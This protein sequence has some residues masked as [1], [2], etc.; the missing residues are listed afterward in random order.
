MLAIANA[1]IAMAFVPGGACKRVQ[2]TLLLSV[3]EAVDAME[4]TRESGH[5]PATAQGCEGCVICSPSIPS[6]RAFGLPFFLA[7]V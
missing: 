3:E 5:K 2:T 1:A 6:G 7:L 4:K